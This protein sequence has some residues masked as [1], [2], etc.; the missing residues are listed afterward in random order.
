MVL[1]SVCCGIQYTGQKQSRGKEG[2]ISA[3]NSRLRSITGGS[4][5]VTTAG[6][7]DSRPHHNHS[8]EQREMGACSHT[9]LLMLS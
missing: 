7:W 5:W 2:T 4:G 3:Y 6:A 8:Q 9:C 1:V